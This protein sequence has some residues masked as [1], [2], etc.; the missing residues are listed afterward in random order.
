VGFQPIRCGTVVDFRGGSVGFVR[1]EFE[2]KF[3][4]KC[5]HAIRNGGQ[6]CPAMVQK[7]KELVGKIGFAKI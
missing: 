6:I 5:T 7:S 1:M 2:A 4:T 3:S